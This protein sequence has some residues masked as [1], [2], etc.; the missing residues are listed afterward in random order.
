MLELPWE[1][2]SFLGGTAT[3]VRERPP[4]PPAAPT[5]PEAPTPAGSAPPRGPATPQRGW[6]DAV[7]ASLD[8]ETTGRDPGSDRILAIALYRQDA[9]GDPTPIVDSLVDPGPAV[10]IPEEASAVH[11]ITRERLDAEQAPPLDAV[12]LEVHAALGELAF[13]QTGVVI[14]NAP[15]DWPFLAAELARLDPPRRL[16]SCH[17][18]DP[19]VLDRHVDRF[20]RGKR[21]LE[22]AC[23]VY[24]VLLDNAHDA[25]ADALASLGVARAIGGRYPEVGRL[26]LEDLTRLQVQAHRTWRDGFN[27]YLQRIGADRAPITGTWPGVTN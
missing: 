18:V 8:L 12:L 23:E 21:T 15:F 2:G 19:L 22:A 13:D 4:R 1:E 5:T 17:L 16:P 11:G 20:R 14:Y 7:L 10:D 6:S 3:A 9:N 25:G 26:H 27:A 24:E